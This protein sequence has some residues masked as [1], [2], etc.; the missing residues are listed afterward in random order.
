[1]TPEQLCVDLI[2]DESVLRLLFKDV[3]IAPP[4]QDY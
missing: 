4:S 1:M 3:G 2:E